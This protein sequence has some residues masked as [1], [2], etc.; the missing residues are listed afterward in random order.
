M[1]RCKK[2]SVDNMTLREEEEASNRP[3]AVFQREEEEKGEGWRVDIVLFLLVRGSCVNCGKKKKNRGKLWFRQ[4]TT[5]FAKL[6][7]NNKKDGSECE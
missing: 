6:V 7:R 2:L 5:Q 3:N 4:A 1:P